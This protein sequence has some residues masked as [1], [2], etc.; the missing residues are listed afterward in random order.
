MNMENLTRFVIIRHCQTEMNAKDQYQGIRFEYPLTEVG[1]DQAN[2]LGQILNEY[3]AN[4]PLDEII[5]SPTLRAQQTASIVS[6]GIESMKVDRRI[7]PFDLGEADGKTKE[8]MFTILGFPIFARKKENFAK[9]L[10]R[11][12]EFLSDTIKQYKG[13]TVLIVTHKDITGI[14]DSYLDNTFLL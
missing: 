6:G 11:I 7:N 3:F 10:R 8:E 4:N 5:V 1:I 2:K 14:I 12:R 13:Q 9:Y